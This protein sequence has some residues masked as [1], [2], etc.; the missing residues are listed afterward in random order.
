MHTHSNAHMY[1]LILQVPVDR[2]VTKEVPVEVEKV[3]EKIVYKEVPYDVEKVVERIVEIPIEKI[4]YQENIVY[5]DKVVYQ[6]TVVAVR[7]SS[8]S[9]F[10]SS[11]P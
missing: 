4:V 2:I 6:D 11:T 10:Y 3:V 1:I 7:T 8:S 9:S 5:E